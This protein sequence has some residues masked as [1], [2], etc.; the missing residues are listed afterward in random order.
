MTSEIARGESHT[1]SGEMPFELHEVFVSRTDSRG[2]IQAG[3]EVFRRTS[4]F[5]WSELTGAPHK[6]VRHPD[7]PKGV[8]HIVWDTLKRGEAIGVYVKNRSKGGEFYWVYAVMV[9]CE[10]GYISARFKPSSEMLGKIE[11][12]YAAQ[13]M[14]EKEEGVDPAKSAEWFLSQLVDQGFPDYA[15]FMSHSLS[16]ELI[17]RD[18][19]LSR[20]EDEGISRFRQMQSAAN[21]LTD[22]TDQLICEFEMTEI[23]PHNMRVIASRLEP[24]GGPISTLSTNYGGMSREMSSWFETHVVGE[25]SNFSTIKG[26][27]AQSMFM[28]CMARILL[29]CARELETE[30]AKQGNMDLE[31]ERVRLVEL[32]NTYGAK[33]EAGQNQVAE[34]T[35]RIFDAC[36]KMNRHMLGLS[37]TRVMCK[38]QWSPN[39]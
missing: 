24:N 20:A 1:A 9:P 23:I 10:D 13:L 22:Q 29:E 32:A 39:N 30:Q 17:S 16:E 19:K 35:Y 18:T 11:K 5:E 15:R 21:Q 38:K 27:V 2:V 37:T 12:L 3:N 8:F 28:K 34:E 36:K 26:T 25:E 14:R 6:I 31:Q 33:S 7:M 4:G